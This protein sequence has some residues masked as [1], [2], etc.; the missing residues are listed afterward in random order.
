MAI[1]VQLPS[2][3]TLVVESSAATIGSDPGCDV[4][5]PED[6]Q[7]Q[8]RH[9]RIKKVANRWMIESEGDW[10][11]QVG[12]GVPGR[13][14]WLKPNDTIRLTES[15]PCIVF[16]SAEEHPTSSRT[17]SGRKPIPADQ[18]DEEHLATA[19]LQTHHPGRHAEPTPEETLVVPPELLV[20]FALK[21]PRRGPPPL[22]PAEEDPAEVVVHPP[23]S[24][25]EGDW[26][27]TKEGK[28][29][30][31][32]SIELMRQLAASGQIRASDLVWRQGM[33]EWVIANTIEGLFPRPRKPGPP[34]LPVED[35]LS[36][37]PSGG[38]PQR[39]PHADVRAD[40]GRQRPAMPHSKKVEQFTVDFTKRGINPY[41]AAPPAWRVA[42]KMGVELPPPHFMAFGT[43]T[44]FS[45]CLFGILWIP[46]ELIMG[47]G[48]QGAA[49]IAI[50]ATLAGTLFGLILAAY[51]R[52]S[53]S[54]LDLPPWD[55][56]PD[57]GPLA[58]QTISAV[59]PP[60]I[61]KAAPALWN[62]RAAG[63]WSLLFSWAFGSFL[64]ARNWAA[65]GDGARTKRCMI[66]FYAIF[67]WMPLYGLIHYWTEPDPRSNEFSALPHLVR[68]AAILIPYF[69]WA[70]TEVNPQTKF[71]KERFSDQYPRKRWWLP[72]T[73][74]ATI[75]IVL[76][77]VSRGLTAFPTGHG[78][79]QKLTFN[80][81]HVFYLAPVTESEARRLGKFLVAN[82]V[83]TGED[84]AVQIRKVGN[85][86][87]YRMVLKKGISPD[88]AVNLLR[89]L[90]NFR[91]SMSK[92]VFNN[93][94]VEEHLCD[95]A[96]NTLRVILPLA[97]SS[98]E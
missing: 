93:A 52:V 16:H 74:A 79:G 4:A 64:L 57:G 44:L 5:L 2:G 60:A 67:P 28:R 36:T 66:W 42:W 84:K 69:M 41:I 78:F 43:L 15:G 37:T 82:N 8:P 19:D 59:G 33:S 62:P 34:P 98:D 45:G 17:I 1:M 29:I 39:L 47:W 13:K 23:A 86:Y 51:Y 30:G 20:S 38:S 9:A 22:P 46:A 71:V 14:Q 89:P 26:H 80:N 25:S 63:L 75:L 65:L 81:G 10:L 95:N 11:I 70:F 73:V 88:V 58:R 27:Y 68:F 96:F 83:F 32:I 12:N 91:R 35:A 31:P 85:T 50:T 21:G 54:H 94:P 53:A 72:L 61:P 77:G 92:E 24:S 76:W 49:F 7:V 40:A 87:Q 97:P 48:S 6:G 3:R 55:Q 90:V 18:S 56:Y